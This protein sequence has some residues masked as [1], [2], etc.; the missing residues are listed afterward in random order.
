MSSPFIYDV[1]GTF[2]V[3]D[4]QFTQIIGNAPITQKFT[5]T[6]PLPTDCTVRNSDVF[7]GD[8]WIGKVNESDASK[9]DVCNLKFVSCNRDD[10]GIVFEFRQVE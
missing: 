8:Y 2:E 9:V 5:I 6:F 3:T 7:Y 10:E 4:K 1:S